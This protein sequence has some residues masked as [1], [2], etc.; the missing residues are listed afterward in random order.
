MPR[1]P[2]KILETLVGAL[3]PPA[4]CEEVLGDLH[5][6]Y[7]SPGQYLADALSTVPFVI[8]S[9]IR[10]GADPQVFLMEALLLW[11]CFLS[12]AWYVDRA[13]IA[14]ALIPAAVALAVIVLDDAWT[15]SRNR[16]VLE[17]MRG[18]ALG[19]AIACLCQAHL[20]PV[21]INLLSG[22]AGL[23]LVSTVRILFR[24]DPGMPKG[25]GRG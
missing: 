7:R 4:C 8:L 3:I 11:A 22:A 9:R 18:V 13:L 15:A 1:G 21:W 25:P 23:L 20:L 10:R 24:I 6:R 19:A 16:T 14:N 5:E 17:S 12:A 2:S